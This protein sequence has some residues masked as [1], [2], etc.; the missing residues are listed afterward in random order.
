MKNTIYLLLLAFITISSCKKESAAS[1][2][3]YQ[4]TLVTNDQ[5]WPVDSDNIHM[6]KFNQGH[7][8]IRVDSPDIITYALAPYANISFPY[9]VQVDG[10]TV[11]DST[12]LTG[13]VAVIFNVADNIDF[14]VA[15]VWTN[16]TYRIWT[17]INGSTSTLVNF[18]Y[19][20]AI[21]TGSGSKNTVKVIQNQSNMELQ[22]NGVSMGTFILPLPSSLVQTGPAVATASNPG[23]TPV[24]GLFNNFSIAK[25]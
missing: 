17:R 18:T 21:K 22:I 16:G 11:L 14:D 25:N 9:S 12:D 10:T 2:V 19:S 20:T 5:T 6:R 15:E 3:V 4:D 1:D 8:S 13:N 23:F 7:Y 24:T